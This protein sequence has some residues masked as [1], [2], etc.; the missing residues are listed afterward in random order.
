MSELLCGALLMVRVAEVACVAVLIAATKGKRDNVI[1]DVGYL[2][3][4]NGL[5][6]L[7]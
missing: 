1:D 5:A 7:A 6:V 4:A 3:A 2:S